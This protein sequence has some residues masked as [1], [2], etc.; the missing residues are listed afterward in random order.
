MIN[1]TEAREDLS[2]YL[3]QCR[4]MCKPFLAMQKIKES[5]DSNVIDAIE[6]SKLASEWKEFVNAEVRAMERTGDL[7][8]ILVGGGK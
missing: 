3:V 7:M 4:K 6:A 2:S 8:M 5:R 1:H